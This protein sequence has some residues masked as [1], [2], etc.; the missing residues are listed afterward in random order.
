MIS[1]VLFPSS[2]FN[3]KQVDEDLQREYAAVLACPQYDDPVLFSYEDWFHKNRLRLSRKPA[4]AVSAVYRGWMM[5]PEQYTQFYHE[6]SDCNI[7]LTTSPEEYS[8]F[9]L[10]PNIYP[11][12]SCDTPKTLVF[13]NGT[14]IHAD[15]LQTHVQRFMVK[16]Y[17]KSVKALIFH[18]IL[19]PPSRRKSWIPNWIHSAPIAAN[20]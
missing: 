8:L 3:A 9:H 15:T 17:V 14:P 12:I 16:D 5:K 7:Q 11:Y 20:C 4:T 6:L 18:C 1:A 19:S 13:P 10:F 2:Y